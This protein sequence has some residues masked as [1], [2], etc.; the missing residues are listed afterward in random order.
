MKQNYKIRINHQI[1]VPQVKVLQ[2]DNFIGILSIGEALKLAQEAGLDL[3]EINPKSNPPICKIVDYGKFK[4]EEKKKA[5]EAK[6]TQKIQQVKELNFRP[7]TDLNDLN[8]KLELAK[9][10]L[11]DGDRV[12]FTV[13]FRGRE[14]THPQL[15]REKLNWIIQEL[16]SLIVPNPF[17]ALEGKLMSMTVYGK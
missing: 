3:I 2:D 16:G 7:N 11:A 17:I 10:F 9:G 12:K 13:K 5:S 15:G 6:K 1:R 4:Y 8:H 14:I